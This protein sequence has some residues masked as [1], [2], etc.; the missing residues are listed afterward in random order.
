MAA[1]AAFIGLPRTT[2]NIVQSQAPAGVQ[3]QRA[4]VT[5]QLAP[6]VRAQGKITFTVN[7]TNNDTITLNGTAWTFKTSGATGPQTNIAGSLSATLTQLISDLTASVDTQVAKCFYFKLGTALLVLDKTPGTGGNAF[8]LAASV[9]TVSAATLTGGTAAPGSATAGTLVSSVPADTAS[10]NALFGTGSHI[11]M[12]AVGFR[13]VNGVTLL[14]ALPLADATGAQPATAQVVFAGTATAVG[15]LFLSV[16]DNTLHT[17]EL[18]LVVGDTP[19]TILTKLET[20]IAA[21]INMPYSNTDD[22]VATSQFTALCGGTHA[23]TWLLAIAGAVPGITVT[24]TGWGSGATNPSL[25]SLLTPIANIRYQ[26]IVWPEAYTLSTIVTF[27]N[28]RK[29][30]NNDVLDGRAFVYK[31]EAL[32]SAQTDSLAANSSEVVLLWNR[33]NATATW[34]GPHTP[35]A[36]DVIAAKFAAARARRFEF[37]ISIS[38]LVTT[39]SANDQF[40][41]LGTA[42]LPYFN[43]PILGVGLP[44]AGTGAVDADQRTAEATGIAVVGVNRAG[45]AVIMGPCVTTWQTDAAGNVDTTWKYLEWRDTHGAIREYQVVNLRT[46]FSQYRL[47]NGDMPAGYAMA[48][49]ALI[50]GYI[51]GLCNDLMKL[52]LIQQ[53]QTAAKFIKSNL[54]VTLNLNTRTVSISELVPMVSQLEVVQGQISF[55]FATS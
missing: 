10:I 21:D 18:D 3:Q 8:T 7:P 16:V 48:N 12:A 40:G 5:G 51:L 9:A 45:T 36:P 29:N 1:P 22:G 53:G 32:S 27:L 11:A 55:T 34:I 41:G 17:Y 31:S 44:A 49:Q 52:A 39:P 25:T 19:A 28:G 15:S 2:L 43:T 46:R 42:S 6:G 26:N 24:L 35:A 38:D 14:D 13:S 33:P 37:G 50:T 47:T 23:N 54:T 30:V 20:A 4:L